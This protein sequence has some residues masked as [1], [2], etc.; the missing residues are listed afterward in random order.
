MKMFL[1]LAALLAT[2]TGL[3]DGLSPTPRNPTVDISAIR[4]LDCGTWVG[5]GFI[6][7]DGVLVTAMHVAAGTQ[8]TDTETGG[9]LMVY[10][11]DLKHD[12]ALL[13]GPSLP[14]DIPYIKVSCQ[15]FVTGQPYLSYGTTFYDQPRPISRMNVIMAKG[16]YSTNA[17]TIDGVPSPGLRVFDNAIAPGMSGGPVIDLE[18]RAHGLN[19][20]GSNDTTMIYEFADGILCN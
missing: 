15:R 17:D 7:A 9:K 13:T 8:C 19:N 5:S 20:A 14:T 4:Y 3:V 18:G 6:I 10:K 11:T 1:L 2:P 12:L 16:Y